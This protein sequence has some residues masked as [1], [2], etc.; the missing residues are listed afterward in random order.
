MRTCSIFKVG[1]VLAIVMIGFG[2]ALV[3]VL[4]TYITDLPNTDPYL[5][6]EFVTPSTGFIV[7]S[8]LL[9]TTDGGKTW[10]IVRR[11]G[12]GTFRS[13]GVVESL[14]RFQF[15]NQE[16]GVTR[17]RDF[18]RRTSDGGQ[19]WPETYSMPMDREHRPPSFFF[20]SPKKG[21]VAGANVYSTEDGG[22]NWERLAATPTGDEYQQPLLW[23]N[24][25]KDGL[26]VTLDG[27]V[28]LT[29]DGGRTWQYVF[30]AGQQLTNVFFTDSSN[31]W[32][33][34]FDGYVARTQ[35]GGRTWKYIR[36]PTS[37][38][39]FSVHFINPNSGCAVGTKCTIICTK[40]GG[41]TW[42]FASVKS[43]PD[44]APILAS[45]SFAN[46]LNGWAVGGFGYQH[47]FDFSW[48]PSKI[49][50]TTK[51][52]GQTWEPVDLPH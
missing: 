14:H 46:E 40:D 34:G 41:V 30:D 2:L 29:N 42:N 28:Q 23:F 31:G 35:D 32:I 15:I 24:T 44:M 27:M 49:A 51:D 9:Q 26:V 1:S 39:L 3:A 37:A 16:V 17:G 8:R 47:S 43:L 4:R 33:V 6:V 38:G 52:G 21:W 13:P 25:S 5:R 20:I 36:T 50:L 19:S 7:G 22:Q 10:K 48:L 45:V 12:D 18:L 11:G